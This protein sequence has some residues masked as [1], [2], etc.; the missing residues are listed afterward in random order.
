ME[1]EIIFNSSNSER[2]FQGVGVSQG[3]AIA[4]AYVRGDVFIEPDKYSIDSSQKNEE[5]QRLKNALDETK[6]QIQNLKEQVRLASGANKE[7]AIFDAHLLVLEDHEVLDK[8]KNIILND[9]LNVEYAFYDIMGRYIRELKKIN[10]RYLRERVVDIEDVMKRVLVNL[11]SVEKAEQSATHDHIL[12]IKELTP[13]DTAQIDHSL[14]KG[15]AT[16]VGSYTSHAAIIA[17][18]LGLP[19]VVGI[20]GLS[21]QLHTGNTILIDGYEGLVI[22]DPSAETLSNYKHLKK[23][24]NKV[25]Q[26]LQ[27]ARFED[28]VTKDGRSITLSAN[29]EF[30][31]EALHAKENGAQGVGLFR[32][33]FFYLNSK[34]LPDEDTQEQIYSKVSDNLAP[35]TL[36]IRTVDIGGDKIP[37][38]DNEIELNP[39]LGWRGIRIS[40]DRPEMF[41][42]QLRAILRSAHSS[43]IGIMFP[44]IST[45]YE[46]RYAKQLLEEVECDLDNEGIPY[47]KPREVGAM[48]EVP[49]AALLS[50][51][52]AKEVDFFSVGT[53]D[54]VQYTL[55]VDRINENVSDLYQPANPAVIKLLDQTVRSG[56]DEGIWVGVCGEMAS[57]LLLTPLLL[58]LGFDEF[59]VGSPQ[60]PAVKYALRKLNYRECKEM[61]K[62]AIK[63]GD[64]E[65]VLNLCREIAN[66]TYPEIIN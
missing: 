10:D 49:S 62:E 36:I 22:L 35:D 65:A 19:A 29:I 17:R 38:E 48:I 46:L 63:C 8:V 33:E 42:T 41:K 24:K 12:V 20:R 60:V 25:L 57:D 64:E 54:L 34:G 2:R 56:H 40:L 3:I 32:T 16:E 47:G 55:A 4:H 9:G 18:S 26:K 27:E 28:P 15:F 39:F 52:L 50:S 31:Y 1:K 30:A 45:I 53:N 13:S 23:E 6:K 14:V 58:G 21:H 5:I 7:E 37:S 51:K 59:S 66:T 44:M 61:A 11:S 43:S